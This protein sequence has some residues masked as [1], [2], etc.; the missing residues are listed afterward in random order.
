MLLYLW[1][2]VVLSAA[3]AYTS[4]EI[5]E[6]GSSMQA[7]NFNYPIYLDLTSR[8]CLVVGGGAVALRKIK[9]LL[10]AGAKVTL[11]AP[12]VIPPLAALLPMNPNLIYLSKSFVHGD[13]KGFFLVIAATDNHEVNAAVAQEAADNGQLANIADDPTA[14]NFIIPAQGHS[15][16]LRFTVATG[17]TPALTKLLIGDIQN[18][19][20]EE[21]AALAAFI[22]EKRE[23]IKA[24][25]LTSKEREALWRKLLTAEAI[26]LAHAG[27]FDQVKENIENAINRFRS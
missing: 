5:Q 7:R 12:M 21:F 27:K 4:L 17:N 16:K 25:A 10:E 20:G 18:I 13:A 14:G 11:I 15:G 9:G 3:K 19:Y 2:L 24:L 6:R 26:T 23:E 8:S 1:C 22:E